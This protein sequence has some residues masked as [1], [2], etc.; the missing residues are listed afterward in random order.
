MG[1]RRWVAL[2]QTPL[3]G[4]FFPWWVS[5]A[6]GKYCK[7]EYLM[8]SIEYQ[9]AVLTMDHESI[10]QVKQPENPMKSIEYRWL[11]FAPL[12]TCRNL[13]ADWNLRPDAGKSRNKM[14]NGLPSHS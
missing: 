4:Q 11:F 2:D 10:P 5:V 12:Q 9:M 13:L 14:R 6:N 8:K 3:H 1:G 7:T